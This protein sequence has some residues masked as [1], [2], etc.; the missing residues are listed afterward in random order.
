[1]AEDKAEDKADFIKRVKG[2]TR[3]RDVLLDASAYYLGLFCGHIAGLLD[4]IEKDHTMI[5]RP[6]EAYLDPEVPEVAQLSGLCN[7]LDKLKHELDCD[8]DLET[9]RK[10]NTLLADAGWRPK[11]QEDEEKSQSRIPIFGGWYALHDGEVTV[12][13]SIS[14]AADEVGGM[15]RELSL[16]RYRP[17]DREVRQ[18]YVQ[19]T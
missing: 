3:D 5:V 14:G 4:I 17:G 8:A 13:A 10:I 7:G 19:S 16:V 18:Y 11:P 1:M 12:C 15:P 9:I 6:V 2:T